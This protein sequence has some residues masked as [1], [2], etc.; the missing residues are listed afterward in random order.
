MSLRGCRIWMKS[1]D[2]TAPDVNFSENFG[3]QTVKLTCFVQLRPFFCV[4]VGEAAP[5]NPR[6]IRAQSA[7]VGRVQAPG[8]KSKK[9]ES[10]LLI[11]DVILDVG[12]TGCQQTVSLY[13]G[14]V[15][16]KMFRI[17]LL[18]DGRAYNVP[19]DLDVRL[20]AVKPDDTEISAKCGVRGG[21]VY[22]L[23][24]ANA[25]DTQGAVR[26]Q[27]R[28]RDHSGAVLCTPEFS[29]QVDGTLPVPDLPQGASGDVEYNTEVL[30]ELSASEDGKTLLF[31]GNPVGAVHVASE[32]PQS[33]EEDAIIYLTGEGL[34][35]CTNDVWV[36]LTDDE[37]IAALTLLQQDSHTHT[38]KAMLD[39]LSA[40]GEDVL[41]SGKPIGVKVIYSGL[42]S[43]SDYAGKIVYN[44]NYNRSGFYF[45]D[46]ISWIRLTD[47]T[48]P[49][50]VDMLWEQKHTH[51]NMTVL[52]KLSESSG[53]LLFDGE[54]IGGV[55]MI[56]GDL[57][58]HAPVGKIIFR[59]G[60]GL[61]ANTGTYM[62]PSCEIVSIPATD[63][64]QMMGMMHTHENEST[65]DKL[66]ESNGRLLFDGTD[67]GGVRVYGTPVALPANAPNG[68]VAVALNDGA[69]GTPI[70]Y[71]A[72][73]ADEEIAVD[74]EGMDLAI[75]TPAYSETAIN[76][77]IAAGDIGAAGTVE[78]E[79]DAAIGFS[80]IPVVSD[81]SDNAYT[82][83]GITLGSEWVAL[84]ESCTKKYVVRADFAQTGLD[85]IAPDKIEEV[86]NGC[87]SLP[88]Q[89]IFAFED[90]SCE[91]NGIQGTLHAGWN[92]LRFVLEYDGRDY[93]ETVDVIIDNDVNINEYLCLPTSAESAQNDMTLEGTRA[94]ELFAGIVENLSTVPGGLYVKRG[95]WKRM[96]EADA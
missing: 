37:T 72:Q 79:T 7:A 4:R 21:S 1:P 81:V 8:R 93:G 15:R 42:P 9:G 78:F 74:I 62:I 53:N 57:P 59:P 63:Y 87:R 22:Y 75:G 47:S 66:T 83:A 95:T 45:S 29:V 80:L 84:A 88:V 23:P 52:D 28:I 71:P 58:E 94:A 60:R 3:K 76:A 25:T 18:Q 2:A 43:V 35:R 92:M 19:Q 64:A 24:A 55:E 86:G 54:T 96:A 90:V 38:N 14:D 10:I 46:G 31:R 6:R 40:S 82:S 30:S 34:F 11:Y 32:L 48:D 69:V 5:R 56:F 16:S 39:N 12:S 91:I 50:A 85:L 26:C 41:Y 61:V 68:S 20:Y 51:E 13:Q 73:T 33:A 17:S 67:I 36:Q 44:T 49:N 77:A 70:M 89:G 65:L 27:V